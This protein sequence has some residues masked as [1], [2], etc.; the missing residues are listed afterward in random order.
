ML[1]AKLAR[2]KAAYAELHSLGGLKDAIPD[3]A[4]WQRELG[5]LRKGETQGRIYRIKPRGRGLR[6]VPRLDRAD[7]AGLIAALEKPA[8][9]T[10]DLA[11][12]LIVRRGDRDL[13]PSLVRIAESAALPAA[14]PAKVT[15]LRQARMRASCRFF[16]L[17]RIYYEFSWIKLA[18]QA[19]LRLRR[20]I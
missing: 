4:A 19:N 12:Q 5:D 3:P 18:G 11:Q 9:V 7:P 8:G 20:R 1:S 2:R 17:I 10:R 16:I 6:P 15:V 13:A 14:S